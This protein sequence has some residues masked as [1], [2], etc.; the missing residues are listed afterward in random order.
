VR[1]D[2]RAFRCSVQFYSHVS[3]TEGIV[4]LL[5]ISLSKSSKQQKI[6]HRTGDMMFQDRSSNC[7]DHICGIRPLYPKGRPCFKSRARQHFSLLSS[8]NADL[9]SNRSSPLTKTSLSLLSTSQ[10]IQINLNPMLQRTFR[11]LSR[12]IIPQLPTR[13]FGPTVVKAHKI[14]H[15]PRKGRTRLEHTSR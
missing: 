9:Q 4:I 11:N 7:F 3:P 15:Q 12:G 5:P 13:N 2:Q 8:R 1:K 6:N 10:P 14:L